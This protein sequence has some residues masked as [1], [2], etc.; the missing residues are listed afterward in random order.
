MLAGRLRGSPRCS[1]FPQLKGHADVLFTFLQQILAVVVVA[2][3]AVVCG[4]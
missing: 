3:V 1:V 2:A 4:N